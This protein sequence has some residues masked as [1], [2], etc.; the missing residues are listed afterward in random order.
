MSDLFRAIPAPDLFRSRWS[1]RAL[2]DWALGPALWETGRL[3]TDEGDEVLDGEIVDRC[4]YELLALEQALAAY[5][6]DD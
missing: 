1:S 6:S 2:S 4:V 3:A 5:R